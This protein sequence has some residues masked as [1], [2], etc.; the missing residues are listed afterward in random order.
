MITSFYETICSFMKE[1]K[2]IIYTNTSKYVSRTKSKDTFLINQYLI[3]TLDM[4]RRTKYVN[5][6]FKLK[7]KLIM[8][9][10]WWKS[11]MVQ[12]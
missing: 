4:P 6:I 10:Y 11:E 7:L 9:K 2:T 1:K 12:K 8:K 5:L 3:N